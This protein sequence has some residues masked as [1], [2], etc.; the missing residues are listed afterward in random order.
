MLHYLRNF[1]RRC[2]TWVE[3]SL[4]ALGIGM[5]LVVATQVFCRYI[6]NSSLF[7]SE[8]L[9]RYMLV[10]I[11]FLGATTAYYRGMHPGVDLVVSRLSVTARRWARLCAH[12]VCL[13]FFVAVTVA[14]VQFTHFIRLQISPSLGIS[15]AFVLVIIPVSGAI[16]FFHALLFF[17]TTLQRVDHDE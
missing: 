11:S 5:S 15:K 2:N 3:C 6:L 4:F 13:L 1:C 10:W 12:A 7:W 9:A 17:L 8:E 14:G 16:L